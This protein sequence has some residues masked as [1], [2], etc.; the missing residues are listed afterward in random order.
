MIFIWVKIDSHH[1]GTLLAPPINFLLKKQIWLGTIFDYG[2]VGNNIALIYSK[3]FNNYSIG[4]NRFG[5]AFL[6][7]LNKILLILTCQKIIVNLSFE[8]GKLLFL[9]IFTLL[10][11]TLTSY[12][13]AGVT[14]FHPRLFMF[15]LFFF[16]INKYINVEKT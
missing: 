8:K 5:G 7:L 4:I 11:L 9:I 10:T 1:E 12:H 14:P 16:I 3:F 15:L 13:Y 2:A 6:I